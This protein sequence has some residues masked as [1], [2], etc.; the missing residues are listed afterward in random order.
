VASQRVV[1][2]VSVGAGVLEGFDSAAG[3]LRRYALHR[4]TSVAL[5]G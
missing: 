2:P 1:D 4:I 5:T 3:E